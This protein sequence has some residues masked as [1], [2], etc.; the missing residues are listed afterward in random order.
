[1]HYRLRDIGIIRLWISSRSRFDPRLKLSYS[2]GWLR[3]G[4]ESLISDSVDGACSELN[5]PNA[6]ACAAD[7]TGMRREEKRV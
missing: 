1:M 2:L 4:G 5:F 7:L 3:R 6:R